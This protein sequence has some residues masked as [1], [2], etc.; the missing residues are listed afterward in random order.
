MTS[1]RYDVIVVGARVAG[2]TVAALMGDAGHKVL[3]IDRA[4]FP[5]PTLSTHF[6]R[7]AWMVSVLHRLDILDEVLALGSPPLVRQYWYEAGGEV[8]AI[9]P[10]QNPGDAGYALSVR[11]EPLDHILVKRAT[12]SPSVELMERSRVT[13]LLWEDGRVAGV[14]LATSEGEKEVQAGIVIGADGRHSFVAH[15]VDAPIE[16]S[17]AGARALYY[18]YVHGWLGPEGASP[19]GPEFSHIADEI[20][21]VFPSDAGMTCVALS[22][23]RD[24]FDQLR[25]SGI[26]KFDEIIARHRGLADRFSAATPEGGL[27]GS[28]PELNYVRVPIGPGWALVGDAGMHQDPWTGLGIDMAGVHA[29]FL[30][31]ALLSWFGGSESE[32]DALAKYHARRNEHCMPGYHQT[33]AL[34]RDL[35][36]LS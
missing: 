6:F 35:R 25:K 3:L 8:P 28:G 21:Y 5:S 24:G 26:A 33:V 27:L 30:A 15:A 12:G 32:A 2:S 10:A 29:T 22:V 13:S 20:A 1:D 23:N 36:Q 7:G 14:R 19:D 18:R 17:E 31:E 9:G 11:R 4:A 34:G 16:E